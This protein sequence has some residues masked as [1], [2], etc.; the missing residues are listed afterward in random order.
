M[1]RRI[2]NV[3][4]END[5][6]QTGRMTAQAARRVELELARQEIDRR[7]ALDAAATLFACNGFDGSP[8]NELARSAGLSLKALYAV[9]PGKE[10]LFEAVIADRYEQHVVPLLDLAR[11]APTAVEGVFALVEDVLA[12]MQTDRSFLILYARGSAGVPAKL[13]AAGRDPFGPYLAAFRNHLFGTLTA[14]LPDAHPTK[15][16][17]IAISLTATMV[18]LAVN[19]FTADPVRPSHDVAAVIRELFTPA[20]GSAST[21]NPGK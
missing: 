13:R 12:A 10:E 14:C 7:R 19:A 1:T 5:N 6:S 9:F 20:L 18:A 17:D 8:M 11:P 16:E 3:R 21:N 4:S 15:I 2:I